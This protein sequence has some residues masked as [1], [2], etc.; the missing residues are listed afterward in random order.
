[1]HALKLVGLVLLTLA[2]MRLVSWGVGWCLGRMLRRHTVPV[3]V[4]ANVGA[5]GIF[6]GFL[7]LN[8]VPDELLD[9]EALVFG[10]IVY[11]VYTGI[12]LKWWPWTRR[13]PADPVR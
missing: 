10:V 11:G 6:A 1:M 4:G 7:V 2:A 12:D 3:R 5:L 9:L 13:P 8:R